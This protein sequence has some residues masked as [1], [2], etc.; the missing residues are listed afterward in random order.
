MIDFGFP[1]WSFPHNRNIKYCLQM[2]GGSIILYQPRR[3]AG[4]AH[5]RRQSLQEPCD[6]VLANLFFIRHIS[7]LITRHGLKL[8]VNKFLYF[9][10]ATC[11]VTFNFHDLL[12]NSSS[13]K[14][15]CFNC[16]FSSTRFSIISLYEL[17]HSFISLSRLQLR[18]V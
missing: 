10:E 1:W 13:I 3:E 12:S 15:C 18:N 16:M 9:K 6:R 2:E 5:L 4:T 7:R 14:I 17:F 8:M 11:H